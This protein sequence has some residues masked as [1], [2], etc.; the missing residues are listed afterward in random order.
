MLAPI[1]AGTSGHQAPRV[2]PEADVFARVQRLSGP[3]P[4][5]CGRHVGQHLWRAEPGY[6]LG[7]LKSSL[8]CAW[9]AAGAR[10]P[11]WLLVR[12]R[13]ID[14]WVATGLVAGDDGVI[15]SFQYDTYPPARLDVSPCGTPVVHAYSDS[16][17][18]ISC[19]EP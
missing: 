19:G 8:D 6:L 3:A 17:G 18:G 10:R 2:E 4:I 12:E 13:G 7:D 14:S 11:F 5:E 9:A 16:R 15:Y 1:L